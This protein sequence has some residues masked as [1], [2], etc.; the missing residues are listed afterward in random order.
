MPFLNLRNM[1]KVIYSFLFLVSA[2]VAFA[3]EPVA[4]VVTVSVDDSRVIYNVEG[5]YE[6][7]VGKGDSF[8]IGSNLRIPEGTTTLYLWITSPVFSSYSFTSS[9]SGL[10]RYSSGNYVQ[11]SCSGTGYNTIDGTSIDVTGYCPSTGQNETF[12]IAF[13]PSY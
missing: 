12:H 13:L 11:L 8:V 2:L 9:V 7:N 10:I 4:P 6:T 5:Y 1:R 3:E